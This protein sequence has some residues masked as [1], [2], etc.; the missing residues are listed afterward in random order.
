MKLLCS[1]C[2]LAVLSWASAAELPNLFPNPG[3]EK[4][5]TANNRPAPAKW[6]WLLPPAKAPFAAFELSTAE[7]HSGNSSMY[8]KD[9]DSSAVNHSLGYTFSP[10]ELKKFDGKILTFSA[11]VKQAKASQANSVGIAVWTVDAETGKI[12]T[13][14]M[15]I[16]STQA[17]DW[18]LLKQK[19]RLPKKIKH[20]HLYF[21][22]A[23]GWGR[24]GEAWFDDVVV[25][26]ENEDASEK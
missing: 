13:A 3:F 25:T 18:T 24:T 26:V 23:Q 9:E 22:C 16:P 7:K 19:I 15:C 12:K 11:W 17:T 1:V 2:M 5:D 14:E 8:L 20:L 21:R 4:W 6:R 10:A